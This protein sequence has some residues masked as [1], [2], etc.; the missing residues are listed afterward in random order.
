[1]AEEETKPTEG[2]GQY[3][4]KLVA[5]LIAALIATLLVR[6]LGRELDDA[7]K[8]LINAAAPL[9]AGLLTGYWWED[10]WKWREALP[11][12]NL[13]VAGLVTAGAYIGL[14]K[15][16]VEVNKDWL[17]VLKDFSP[18]IVGVVVAI[19]LPNRVLSWE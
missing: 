16:G 19:A 7:E 13:V 3:T 1:M 11:P 18:I 17:E 10:H 8:E 5:S 15:L 4:P 6:Y 12:F 2:W 9:M 14:D